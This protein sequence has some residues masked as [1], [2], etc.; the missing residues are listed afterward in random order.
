MDIDDPMAEVLAEIIREN[1]HVAGQHYEVC[2]QFFKQVFRFCFLI[3]FR[4]LRD[5]DVVKRNLEAVCDVAELLV[6][7]N[8]G[9]NFAVELTRSV[10][11][12]DVVEAVT[13]LAHKQNHSWLSL[14]EF[15]GPLH[16]V[17]CTDQG[18]EV[19]VDLFFGDHEVRQ[20]PLD[21]HKEVVQVLVHMLV[22]VKDISPVLVDEFGDQGDEAGLV[23]TMDEEDSA[24][25][26]GEVRVLG[27]AKISY[28]AGLGASCLW[29]RNLTDS[30]PAR[31]LQG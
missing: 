17:S 2:I 5:R 20:V 24:V 8:D 12:Q 29:R 30:P 3:C 7:R 28:L 4:L 31:E 10:A 23:R 13:G 21:A 19:V 18:I 1:L 22:E 6:V 16:V 14:R 15:Q 11:L 27:R 9:W 26:H 25:G